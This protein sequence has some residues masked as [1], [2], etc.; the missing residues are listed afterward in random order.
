MPPRKTKTTKKSVKNQVSPWHVTTIPLHAW[1]LF[2]FFV[3]AT[4]ALT[5][6]CFTTAFRPAQPEVDD[7]ALAMF[8]AVRESLEQQV[9]ELEGKVEKDK[10]NLTWYQ[11]AYSDLREQQLMPNCT[12]GTP[13][14]AGNTIIT[15]SDS[16]TGIQVQLPYNKE[17]GGE[18]CTLPTIEP[19]ESERAVLAL[20]F[21][22]LAFGH[23]IGV[24]R[25]SAIEARPPTSS[26]QLLNSLRADAELR[27]DPE[28]QFDV[29]TKIVNGIPV[30]RL[31]YTGNIQHTVTWY[32][33]GRSY[34]FV[35]STTQ[36]GVSEDEV[37]RII[38]SLRVTQ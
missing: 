31:E 9:A 3:L 24:F 22:R 23:P 7:E 36:G 11:E 27:A 37:T 19:Y 13:E 8:Q 25:S 26:T 2:W 4:I 34:L 14:V 18:E 15:Y 38:Q 17:W 28:N 32:A 21:G 35:I 20:A 30:H 29:S 16:R 6:L 1:I 33:V 5:A 10:E 12:P